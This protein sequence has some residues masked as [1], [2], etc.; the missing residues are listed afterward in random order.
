MR[1]LTGQNGDGDSLHSGL[2]IMPEIPSRMTGLSVPEMD[3]LFLPCSISIS[4]VHHL[5][6]MLALLSRSSGRI[7]L[8]DECA[9]Y[10]LKNGRSDVRTTFALKA[11]DLEA[12]LVKSPSSERNTVHN[13]SLFFGI[14][15]PPLTTR[16][17]DS[18]LGIGAA[19]IGG[20]WPDRRDGSLSVEN[21]LG[22]AGTAG[23]V[24]SRVSAS[25]FLV[26]DELLNSPLAERAVFFRSDSWRFGFERLS[27]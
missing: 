22:K 2:S 15:R 11:T 27:D 23:V 10:V 17:E 21:D 3:W 13:S 4:P 1:K 20:G 14:M 18:S 5:L 25:P 16:S 24:D 9:A 26:P 19:T 6:R 12:N 7:V 8:L